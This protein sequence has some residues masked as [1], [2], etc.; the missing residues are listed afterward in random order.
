MAEYMEYEWRSQPVAGTAAAVVEGAGAKQPPPEQGQRALVTAV[1]ER[2]AANAALELRGAMLLETEQS[3]RRFL[4]ARNWEVERAAELLL[5]YRR[6]LARH[7]QLLA[8][9]GHGTPPQDVTEALRRSLP[10]VLEERDR[11]GRRVLVMFSA[12]WDMTLDLTAVYRA[13]WFTLERLTCSCADREE[14]LSNGLVLVV[15]W[16]ELSVRA[17]AALSPR[18]LRDMVEGLQDCFP[19]R[20]KAVHMLNQPWWLEPPL[21]V[22]KRFLSERSRA[23][24]HTHGNNLATLHE[25]LP[26]DILPAQ[27]GGERPEHSAHVFLASMSLSTL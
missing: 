20:F 4:Y 27:L 21:L 23:R 13:L 9:L 5:A 12:G 25:H 24:L 8:G 1:R 16:S 7:G 10:G 11:R 22:L 17:A 15:D 3:L 2:A 19:A 6:H 26:T 14:N 18:L